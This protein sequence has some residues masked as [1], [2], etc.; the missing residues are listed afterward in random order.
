[1]NQD[2]LGMAEQDPNGLPGIGDELAKVIAVVASLPIDQRKVLTVA[3]ASDL[4]YREIAE[5]GGFEAST[6]L[7]WMRN[8]LHA[9]AQEVAPSPVRDA[10]SHDPGPDS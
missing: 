5:Q 4:T 1:V 7:S 2:V 6:V 8:G 3:V 9:I 10:E